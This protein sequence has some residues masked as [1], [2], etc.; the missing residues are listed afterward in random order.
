MAL[1]SYITR[2]K[3]AMDHFLGE[4]KSQVSD[5]D[6][7]TLLKGVLE[8]D[9]PALLG[10]QF[11]ALDRTWSFRAA[12]EDDF[13]TLTNVT[14]DDGVSVADAAAGNG[15]VETV[16][17]DLEGNQAAL[18]MVTADSDAE[19]PV[20]TLFDLCLD[21]NPGDADAGSFLHADESKTLTWG[22]E[23]LLDVYPTDHL[24][25]RV[26]VTGAARIRAVRLR[27]A[28]AGRGLL[29]KHVQA[30][31][32]MASASFFHERLT[33]AAYHQNDSETQKTLRDLRDSLRKQAKGFLLAPEAAGLDR[34]SGSLGVLGGKQNKYFDAFERQTRNTG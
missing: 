16:P 6:R 12:D 27:L 26:T 15:V 1:E 23:V 19:L 22:T 14:L 33:K 29:S 31:A 5:A 21:G 25:L 17:I 18:A 2:M 10:D 8:F 4:W 28:Y 30:I 11:A 34:S 3:S 20:D 7:L 24:V 32:M 9:L 13:R